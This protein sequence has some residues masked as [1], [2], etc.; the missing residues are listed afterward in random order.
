MYQNFA[1]MGELPLLSYRKSDLP[2]EFAESSDM[3]YLRMGPGQFL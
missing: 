2:L 1:D 3:S